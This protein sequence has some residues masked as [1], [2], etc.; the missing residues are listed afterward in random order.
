MS[1]IIMKIHPTLEKDLKLI[2]EL[3][4]CKV[5]MMP[6]SDNAWAVLVPKR[7]KG[8]DSY[9]REA[10]ELD[11]E[12]QVKL[13]RETSMVSKK[14]SEIFSADK[15]NVAALGNMVPQLHI[16]IICRYEGDKAWPGPIWGKKA[17][18][19]QNK[20]SRLKILETNLLD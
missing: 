4:L 9:I 19:E 15:M 14:M 1:G 18:T 20:L 13:T 12:D 6:D 11:E 7:L 17:G 2:G 10:Y 5:F 8:D 16:H 3:S